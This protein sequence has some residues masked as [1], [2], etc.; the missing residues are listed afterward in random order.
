MFGEE[1]IVKNHGRRVDLIGNIFLLCFLLILARLWYLQLYKGNLFLR[2]SLENQLRK[3]VV[4]APRGM[5]FS[6]DNQL[7]VNNVPRLDLVIVPQYFKHREAVFKKLSGIMHLSVESLMRRY[8]KGGGQERFRAIT[9]KKNLSPEEVA[10]IETESFD[11]PGVQVRTFIS[12]E[13]SD[14]EVGSHVLGYISEISKQ[15]LPKY[16]KRDHVNY[17]LGDFIGQDGIE[18]EFDGKLRG[19][20]G[21]EFMEVDALG[22]MKRHL[23]DSDLFKGINNIDSEP[24][25]NI[26][27]T[28]DRDLQLEAYKALEGKEGSAVA[29]DVRTGE[30]LAMVSRPA[31]DPTKFSE[32]LT[33]KYWNSLINNPKRPMRNRSIQEHYSPGSTFKLFTALTA[34]EEGLIDDKTQ[35]MCPPT[36]RLGR[37][38]YHD[39]KRS[40]F[41]LTDVYKSIK[42]SVDVYYYKIGAKLDIDTLA[43]YAKLFGFSSK[44]GIDLPREISGLIPTKEWKLKKNGV[45]WQQGETISCVIGQS[46]VLVTP[47]QLALAYAA[48]A[49]KGTLYRPMIIKDIFNNDGEIIKRYTPE[50]RHK[51][52]EVSEKTF[53]I[54][55]KGLYKAVNEPHG[56][57]YWFR[58]RG[59]EMAGKTGTSQ[60]IGMNSKRLFAKCEEHPYNERHHGIFAAF[61]PAYNPR[62][63]VAVVVEHGCHG[64]TAAAPVAR[65]IITKYMKK[66]YPEEYKKNLKAEKEKAIRIQREMEREKK[67]QERKAQEAAAL[68]ANKKD[69]EEVE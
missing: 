46:Y 20:D 16:R 6:R 66:Y 30:V 3:E 55:H 24:G 41:G 49:N 60:V 22:R 4:K 19:V 27:L 68:E 48:I 21:Y 63:A 25:K 1:Q 58:G 26:R 45:E 43:H 47:L 33:A 38:R 65:D 11:L 61:A 14:K 5:I 50:V 29:V 36:F 10:R 57:A 62:I 52:T 56:T 7:L 23:S 53:N 69:D 42:R 39:W 32:G 17:K 34:L 51:I 40:G 2:H 44:T 12:R 28:L 9:I 35:V 67:R 31:Y 54:L 59:I 37:R 13:Y 8:K 15:Q 64:S 18:Q